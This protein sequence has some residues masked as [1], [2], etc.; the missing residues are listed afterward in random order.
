MAR[1]P[2]KIGSRTFRYGNLG[3]DATVGAILEHIKSQWPALQV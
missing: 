3:D 1:E 2:R